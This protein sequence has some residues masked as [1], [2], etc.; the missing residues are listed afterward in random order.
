MIIV[1]HWTRAPAIRPV[2]EDG[3]RYGEM[4]LV[5]TDGRKTYWF[6]TRNGTRIIT[7]KTR[8]NR[9]VFRRS[10]ALVRANQ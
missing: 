9:L 3:R 4:F 10:T 7:K 1:L 6:S 5:T 2:I 8:K